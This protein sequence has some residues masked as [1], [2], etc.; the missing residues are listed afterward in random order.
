MQSAQA[1][2]RRCVRG[3][4]ARIVHVGEGEGEAHSVRSPIRDP[5]GRFRVRHRSDRQ[6]AL[7]P[8]DRDPQGP[9]HH[10][11][12]D[13]VH[14]HRAH[15]GLP[16]EPHQRRGV[17]EDADLPCG[18]PGA[19]HPDHG[20]AHEQSGHLQSAYHHAYRHRRRAQTQHVHRHD[21]ARHQSGRALFG[22]LHIHQGRDRRRIRRFRHNNRG[23][24]TRRIRDQGRCDPSQ[25]QALRHPAAGPRC[26]DA[27]RAA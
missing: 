13:G 21:D 20:R 15:I 3:R 7:H 11:V 4:S 27:P 25:G 6:E 1:V 18:C 10:M 23:T 9:G 12:R 19:G 8:M 14:A 22:Y 24:D 5:G 2:V 16:H 17:P 26:P